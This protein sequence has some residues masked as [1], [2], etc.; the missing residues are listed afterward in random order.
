VKAI[1]SLGP[2]SGSAEAAADSGG[3]FGGRKGGVSG[4][5]GPWASAVDAA[6]IKNIKPVVVPSD[7]HALREMLI[8]IPF[9]L[10]AL[11][12]LFLYDMLLQRYINTDSMS[13]QT[14]EVS[15]GGFPDQGFAEPSCLFS[16][17]IQ[18]DLRDLLQ[19]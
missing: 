18:Q 13:L 5:S 7:I 9:S 4:S 17:G 19:Q 16:N 3:I 10:L 11:I 14:S 6:Q 12:S 8:L 15:T 1:V 2:P